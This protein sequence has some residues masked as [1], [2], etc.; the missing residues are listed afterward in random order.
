MSK[1]G[2][3]E[4]IRGV[5]ALV[6]VN[7]HLLKL[8]FLMAFSDA[9]M[10]SEGFGILEELSF[11]PFNMMHNGAWA[12]CVFF[13]LSGYVLSHSFFS[14]KHVNHQIL[15][16]S[17]IARYVR[18]AI[19]ITASLL[20]VWL[21]M[22][23]DL[24]QF[25]Q[26]AELT[27]TKE[28]NPYLDHLTL[29]EVFKQ[30]FGS[31]LFLDNYSYN[32]PLWTMSVEM[33]GSIGVFILQGIFLAF[34]QANNAWIYRLCIYAGL[35]TLLFPTLYI[36]FLLGMLLCDLR[37]NSKTNEILD[38]YS[39]FWV[40]GS[41][42]VGTVLSAYM[43]RGLYSNPFKLITFN[44]FNPYHEYL[45][46]TWGAFFLL[47]GIVYSKRI[48]EFFSKPIFLALGKIS[49]PLYLVH[50]TVMTSL[51]AFLYISLPINDHL[52]KSVLSILISLPVMF[53][54]AYYFNVAINEP[55]K[56]VTILIK[57]MFVKVPMHSEKGFESQVSKM[58]P[59]QS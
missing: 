10:R 40:P 16:G 53:I 38:S 56:K 22:R 57:R 32:P 55:A 25:T 46:N 30:G 50:Y 19:P 6:V 43:I 42:L 9:A 33:I 47:A 8:F 58:N 1:I 41:L 15:C 14:G 26:V 17:L 52:Y 3:F 37:N 35:I 5:A 34:K 13:V 2:H 11:P 7:E 31:A 44:G 51:T 59:E 20:L 48:S 49:F 28:I 18:L 23:F 36:G 4:G 27:Q 45:Y 29:L 21:F 24:F 54:V 39:K 12:V